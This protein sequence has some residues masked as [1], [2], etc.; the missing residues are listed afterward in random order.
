M[1]AGDG[2]GSGRA[3]AQGARAG[4]GGGA[5]GGEAA[6]TLAL[7]DVADGRGGWAIATYPGR[8]PPLTILTYSL[9]S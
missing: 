7:G 8:T 3:G 9:L 5:G 4:R 2:S 6:A 1:V